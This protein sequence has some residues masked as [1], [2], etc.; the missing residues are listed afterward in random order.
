MA[1]EL[2]PALFGAIGTLVGGGVTITANWIASRTQFRL[3][4]D[5]DRRQN[6]KNRNDA[7][8]AYLASAKILAERGHILVERMRWANTPEE[9]ITSLHMACHEGWEDVLRKHSSVLVDSPDIEVR[10]SANAVR[11][12]LQSVIESCNSAYYGGSGHTRMPTGFFNLLQAARAA[13]Q[14]FAD[15]ANK[16]SAVGELTLAFHLQTGIYQEALDLP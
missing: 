12:A 10:G 2:L 5:S 14:K 8:A 3:A 6:V 9:T 1:S 13:N 16:Y 7:N 11:D 15:D 4:T